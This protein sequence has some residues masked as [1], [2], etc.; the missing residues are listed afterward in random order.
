MFWKPAHSIIY[1]SSIDQDCNLIEP[2][3]AWHPSWMVVMSIY[4]QASGRHDHR[5][6]R[7]WCYSKMLFPN[8]GESWWSWM[9]VGCNGQY[10]NE[11]LGEE[12]GEQYWPVVWPIIMPF[13]HC[14]AKEDC[15]KGIRQPN[16]QVSS[17]SFHSLWRNIHLDWMQ[18]QIL[19]GCPRACLCMHM[20]QWSSEEA[21]CRWCP[22]PTVDRWPPPQ[23]PYNPQALRG[24]C[25]WLTRESM[26]LLVVDTTVLYP[27]IFQRCTITGVCE[28]KLWAYVRGMDGAQVD[29]PICTCTLD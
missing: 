2:W 14:E 11:Y 13:I 5:R 9:V 25:H 23:S 1:S 15:Y 12:G 19:W 22:P 26:E 4:W 17:S 7:G 18:I 21:P 28:C 27:H 6:Q 10:M 3:S 8:G 24:K 16:Q 29:T 20:K